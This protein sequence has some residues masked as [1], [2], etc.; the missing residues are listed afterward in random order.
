MK[1]T[2]TLAAAFGIL[3]LAVSAAAQDAPPIPRMFKG[4]AK[5]QWKVEILEHSQMKPGKSVPAMTIC[6]DNLAQQAGQK[7]AAKKDTKCKHKLLKDGSD[8]AVWEIACPERTVTTTMKRESAKVVMADIRTTGKDAQH[9]TMRYTSLGACREGQ[10]TMTYDKNSEVCKKVQAQA[11]QLD[12][13]KNCA[14]AKGD[15]RVQCE[16]ALRDQIAQAKA[17][18]Q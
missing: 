12:P 10:S 8:E 18:C 3:G 1:R 2:V 13:A 4:M 17:M 14:G 9:M 5:G 16:K 15:Q 6:A 11:A 7:P